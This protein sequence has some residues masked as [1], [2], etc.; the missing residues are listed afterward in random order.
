M[1]FDKTSVG[2]L[3]ENPNKLEEA[4]SILA[5]YDIPIRRLRGSKIEIQSPR[6]ETIVRY[7]L[8]EAI[9]NHAGLVVVE[10]S[11]LFIDALGGFPG[12]FSSYI[13]STIGLG[14][15]LKLLGPR[16]E[17]FFQSSVGVGSRKISPK[18]FTGIVRGKISNRISGGGG[19]GYDPVFIPENSTKTFAENGREFKNEYSHRAV[20]FRK[21]AEW[22]QHS[23]SR[24]RVLPAPTQS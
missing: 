21:F 9:R 4:R 18:V 15:V 19:F 12:P 1:L 24:R 16:R 3:T 6:L 14:G 22:F 2:F 10:D 8:K 20:A 13:Y 11:G 23:T 5:P 17:A 7:A